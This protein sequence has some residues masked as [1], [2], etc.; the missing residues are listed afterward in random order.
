MKNNNAIQER[1][2]V[3]QAYTNQLRAMEELLNN[4]VERYN[5]EIAA[6]EAYGA[7]LEKLKSYAVEYRAPVESAEK[8]DNCECAIY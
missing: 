7:E 2:R 3:S 1:I 8:R 4:R 6:G 5:Q